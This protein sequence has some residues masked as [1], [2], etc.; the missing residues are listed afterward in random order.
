MWG[1]S[2]EM[3]GGERVEWIWQED[4][5]KRGE[6]KFTG[7]E[8]KKKKENRKLSYF[9]N[10]LFHLVFSP[11]AWHFLS[12]NHSRTLSQRFI[13]TYSMLFLFLFIHTLICRSWCSSTPS[14]KVSVSQNT[15]GKTAQNHI[16]S[17][18]FILHLCGRHTAFSVICYLK[19]RLISFWTSEWS[20]T[21][22]LI[23]P[24]YKTLGRLCHFQRG[25]TLG[26]T[27]AL[28]HTDASQFVIVWGQWLGSKS[29]WKNWGLHPSI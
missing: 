19:K 15:L 27:A 22:N 13:F 26:V 20:Q 12:L 6:I 28:V 16:N 10:Y 18:H 23:N 14:Y 7:G 8:A 9:C 4:C 21:F 11:P 29:L 3:K 25:P 1:G 2:A 17:L 5:W 24:I